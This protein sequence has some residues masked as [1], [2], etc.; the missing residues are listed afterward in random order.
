VKRRPVEGRAGVALVRELLFNQL[1]AQRLTRLDMGASKLELDLAGREIVVWIY[2]LTGVDGAAN[3][4]SR[5]R[6]EASVARNTPRICDL[7]GAM[8]TIM[9]TNVPISKTVSRE[10]QPVN[11]ARWLSGPFEKGGNGEGNSPLLARTGDSPRC[12]LRENGMPRNVG[13]IGLARNGSVEAAK[14]DGVNW[15]GVGIS[16][17]KK[18]LLR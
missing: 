8:G 15:R 14:E 6:H 18:W 10:C 13:A 5:G 1:V 3:R 11:R 12:G 9:L 2:R 16:K 7:K 4:R 17:N